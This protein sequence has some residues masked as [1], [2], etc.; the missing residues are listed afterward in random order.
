MPSND[1]RRRR[2]GLMLA[3]ASGCVLISTAAGVQAAD[4][5]GLGGLFQSLFGGGPAQTAAPA[6]M[7]APV[8][9]SEAAPRLRRR[10]ATRN[11]SAEARAALRNRA[12]YVALPKAGP[13]EKVDPTKPVAIER[14]TSP[15]QA[16]AALMRDPTLRPGDIV[17]L[18]E[19]PRVFMGEA[20]TTKHRASEFEDVRHSRLVNAQTR[21]QLL[22]MTTPA[23][24]LPA[25]EARKV[26]ARLTR[27]GAKPWSQ[28]AEARTETAMR[29]VYPA[30]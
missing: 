25:D 1:T 24:A 29:V 2:R 8:P 26:M 14:I 22:A 30:R 6:P 11:R 9:M 12:R 5:G 13:V 19:G 7:A 18:P 16:R 17:I 15:S 10:W 4:E 27:R 3:L 28:P 20:G 23:G 21:R